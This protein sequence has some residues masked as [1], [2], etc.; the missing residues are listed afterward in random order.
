MRPFWTLRRHAAATHEIGPYTL[1]PIVQM[2]G[3]RW[4]G[5]GWLWQFPLAVEVEG[6]GEEPRRLPIP[7]ATRTVLWFLYALVSLFIA[8][9]ILSLWL[10]R[11]NRQSAKKPAPGS[12]SRPHTSNFK[13]GGNHV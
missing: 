13:V 5:G 8:A 11:R 12:K 9:A 1:T 2:I 7:D 3:L 4:P 10:Q 6:A